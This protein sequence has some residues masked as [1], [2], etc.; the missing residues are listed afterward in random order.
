ML[1]CTVYSADIVA[2]LLPLLLVVIPAFVLVGTENVVVERLSSP[3]R[4]PDL[5]LAHI[6]IAYQ[7]YL[8]I[9]RGLAMVIS[10]QIMTALIFSKLALWLNGY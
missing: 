1:R 4:A 7:L 5:P 6:V 8:R 10:S 9:S 2:W 3:Y